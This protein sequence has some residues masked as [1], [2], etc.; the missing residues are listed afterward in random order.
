MR[1]KNKGLE[2]HKQLVDGEIDYQVGYQEKF[3]ESS[4][5]FEGLVI[6]LVN[7]PFDKSIPQNAFREE[8]FFANY[9]SEEEKTINDI[10][11]LMGSALIGRNPYKSD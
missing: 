10:L 8:P 4:Q 7:L 11:Y 2:F 3:L 5:K 1:E 9:T 6:K